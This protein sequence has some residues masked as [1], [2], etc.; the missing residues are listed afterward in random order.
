[1]LT[2]AKVRRLELEVLRDAPHFAHI[3]E[4]IVATYRRP[5]L[6]RLPEAVTPYRPAHQDQWLR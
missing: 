5:V 1:M 6:G 4:V 2:T 3:G